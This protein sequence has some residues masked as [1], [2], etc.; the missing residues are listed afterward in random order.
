MHNENKFHLLC[1]YLTVGQDS[2]NKLMQGEQRPQAPK[3]MTIHDIMD[4]HNKN[5]A[6]KVEN[7]NSVAPDTLPSPLTN[8]HISILAD[9]Y[10]NAFGLRSDIKKASENPT[11]KDNDELKEAIE[12]IYKKLGDIC[13]LVKDTSNDLDKFSIAK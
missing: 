8:N 2:N 12:S 9:I 3:H 5:K 10:S 7:D 4:H 13:D 11:V 6:N 1:E